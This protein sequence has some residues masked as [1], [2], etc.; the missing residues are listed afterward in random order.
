MEIM[1]QEYICNQL[2]CNTLNEYIYNEIKSGFDQSFALADSYIE[3]ILAEI[4]S[5]NPKKRLLTI[6]PNIQL[7]KKAKIESSEACFTHYLNESKKYK[8]P[9]TI[10][11]KDQIINLSEYIVIYFSLICHSEKEMIDELKK[12]KNQSFM[13]Y[14]SNLIYDKG[15]VLFEEI[16][17]ISEIKPFEWSYSGVDLGFLINYQIHKIENEAKLDINQFEHERELEKNK[18]KLNSII[19]DLQWTNKQ[20]N[21]D[22]DSSRQRAKF[23][24]EYIEKYY[25]STQ[26]LIQP[27]YFGDNLPLIH[28][29]Y[30]FL[31]EN[32]CFDYGWSYFY[33]CLTIE[34][35]EIINLKNIQNNYFFGNLFWELSRFLKEPYKSEFKRFFN[36]KF[37]LGDKP[38]K[39]S[40]F[41]NYYR[42]YKNDEHESLEVIAALILKL[43]KIYHK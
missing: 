19:E 32:N 33:T 37:Y 21:R 3:Q 12:I 7:I 40:F 13:Y 11:L 34:N 41:R 26:P 25:Y 28:C 24:E 10:D 22:L 39:E 36:N 31:K 14:F 35:N 30:N 4:R 38:L 6:I 23:L 43:E 8:S 9:Q 18:N 17:L 20:L 1:N 2:Q 29:L 5:E 27:T 15:V 42:K 16:K